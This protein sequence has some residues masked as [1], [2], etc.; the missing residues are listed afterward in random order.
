MGEGVFCPRVAKYLPD[1]FLG[2]DEQC[3]RNIVN[4][5]IRTSSN[6][7]PSSKAALS[8]PETPPATLSQALIPRPGFNGHKP[9]SFL[10]GERWL[11]V[12][13]VNKINIMTINA[14][15]PVRSGAVSGQ[16]PTD[17]SRGQVLGRAI[18]DPLDSNDTET[19]LVAQ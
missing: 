2:M 3:S 9:T 8:L 7:L 19:H 14:Y 5:T 13:V 6:Y 1:G 10:E 16:C 15:S 11:K 18:H 12:S 17:E 4:K